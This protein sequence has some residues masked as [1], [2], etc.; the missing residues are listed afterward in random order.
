LDRYDQCYELVSYFG[1]RDFTGGYS[2]PY[3]KDYPYKVIRKELK[4]RLGDESKNFNL[5]I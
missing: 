5:S 3:A 1:D 4:E 2:D